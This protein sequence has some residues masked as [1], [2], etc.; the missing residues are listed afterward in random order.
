M[1]TNGIGVISWINVKS[2]LVYGLLAVILAIIAHGSI[3][4]LDKYALVDVAVM[5]IL[6]SFVKNFLTTN[7]GN[8]AGVVKV[9]DAPTK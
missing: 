9:I 8:F 3:F 2:A 7:D 1:K 6:T 4:G 5:G